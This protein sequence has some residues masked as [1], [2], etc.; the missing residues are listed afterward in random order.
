MHVYAIKGKKKKKKK[1]K[2]IMY[3]QESVGWSD[4]KKKA[5]KRNQ[6]LIIANFEQISTPK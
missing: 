3:L 5:C 1:P 4:I 6:K 2:R